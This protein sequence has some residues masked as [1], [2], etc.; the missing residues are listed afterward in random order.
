MLL[1]SGEESGVPMGVTAR[2]NAR[3]KATRLK[4]ES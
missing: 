2:A 1:V 3:N 4:K